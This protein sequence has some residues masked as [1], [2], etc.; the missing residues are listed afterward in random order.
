MHTGN[1]AEHEQT[2]AMGSEAQVRRNSLQYH[3]SGVPKETTLPPRRSRNTKYQDHNTALK[4]GKLSRQAVPDQYSSIKSPIHTIPL[5]S[6]QKPWP[7]TKASGADELV[8]HMSNVPSYLQHRKRGDNLQGKALNVGVLDWGLLERW[9][10]NKRHVLSRSDRDSPSS[11]NESSSFY[12]FGSS[13]QSCG[14]TG[15]PLPCGNGSPS[16]NGRFNPSVGIRNKKEKNKASEST[17]RK[18]EPPS[19]LVLKAAGAQDGTL[20]REEN[21]QHHFSSLHLGR[22]GQQNGSFALPMSGKS[23]WD[24]LEQRVDGSRISFESSPTKYRGQMERNCN[25]FSIEVLW[26]LQQIDQPSHIS[27]SCP[28]PDTS[29]IDEPVISNGFLTENILQGSEAELKTERKNI[30]EEHTS[31]RPSQGDVSTSLATERKLYS[32][33]SSVGPAGMSRSSSLRYDSSVQQLEPTGSG[34]KSN[35][36]GRQSPLRRILDPFIKPKNHMDFSSSISSSPRHLSHEAR[37]T[38]KSSSSERLNSSNGPCRLMDTC[39]NSTSPRKRQALLQLAWKNGLPLFMLS[40]SGSNI[41]AAT[42]RKKSICDKNDL[43]C[44][45]TIFTVQES[46][47]KGRIWTKPGNKGKKHQ[48]LS[49]VVGEMNVSCSRSMFHDSKGDHAVRQ[50]V[51]FGS[52]L[53]PTSNGPTDSQFNCE[54]AAILVKQ[55]LKTKQNN[56]SSELSNLVAIL[57]RSIHGFS[58]SGKPSPLIE[59]W[60]SGGACDCGGWDEGC[61][62]TILADE[63]QDC[64]TSGS[65]RICD[66]A[67]GT[68]RIELFVQVCYFR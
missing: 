20:N 52:E 1:K 7:V 45:Y 26:D 15:S 39:V 30:L 10:C 5:K 48:F 38:G 14:S 22:E 9:T 62:L 65:V 11:S 29:L 27:H 51:L 18:E 25:G 12:T 54:L 60:R 66:D 42:V 35:N 19:T 47:R 63:L 57:P 34:N 33:H 6:H 40:S 3:F 53:V 67:D 37:Y 31:N 49:S 46:K 64:K 56:Q 16:A 21:I 28:L 24:H 32:H 41:L 8:K 43:E 61:A 44:V 55:D 17:S 13:N 36:R 59:R 23:V 50:F 58:T 4:F 68:Q 2:L